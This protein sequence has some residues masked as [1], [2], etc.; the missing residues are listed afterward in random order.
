M[1]PN[2]AV[3]TI[4][5]AGIASDDRGRL[6]FAND[7]DLLSVRRMYIVENFAVGTVRAWHGHQHEAK[8]VFPI[9]GA[10]LVCAVRVDD[11]DSPSRD[12]EVTRVVLDAQNP[13]AFAIP[14]GF[15]NGA[16]S[17]TQGARL[18]YLSSATLEESGT[19][20]FRYPARYWDPWNIVER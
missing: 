1:E 6:S 19:D 2:T 4:I 13:S 8:W 14:G 20:D 10:A 18:L 7:L 3:P 9:D 17:L 11:W 16:M 15:A 5:P 12:S